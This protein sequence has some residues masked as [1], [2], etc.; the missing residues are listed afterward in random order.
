[1]KMKER[2]KEGR[3]EGKREG[4]KEEGRWEEGKDVRKGGR[5][6]MFT[7]LSCYINFKINFL[8]LHSNFPEKLL[9]L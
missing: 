3:K 5:E 7:H 9:V 1:M 2:K 6:S 4:R 8:C